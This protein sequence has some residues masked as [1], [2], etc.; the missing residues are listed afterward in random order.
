MCARGNG[1]I[2]SLN[3]RGRSSNSQLHEMSNIVLPFF[4]LS[5]N[6]R[7][8]MNRSFALMFS[9]CTRAGNIAA[10]LKSALISVQERR[11]WFKPCM[12]Q[13]TH[14]G[15]RVRRSKERF[16]LIQTRLAMIAHS[17][18]QV[19][20]TNGKCLQGSEP[21]STITRETNLCSFREPELTLSCPT[22]DSSRSSEIRPFI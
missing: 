16:R 21:G 6:K 14:V 4:G 22:R 17:F 2:A 10:V 12:S 20:G 5:K 15:I 1:S 3:E 13:F 18:M 11:G 8:I 19:T 7:L 9:V